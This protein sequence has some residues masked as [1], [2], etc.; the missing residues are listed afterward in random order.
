MHKPAHTIEQ[1]REP[2]T[3]REKQA[4][5]LADKQH[6]YHPNHESKSWNFTN[7]SAGSDECLCEQRKVVRQVWAD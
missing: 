5:T 2:N 7:F 1:T 3:L 4:S 6:K